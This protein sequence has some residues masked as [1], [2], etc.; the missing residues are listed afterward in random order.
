M[1]ARAGRISNLV[2]VSGSPKNLWDFSAR[3]KLYYLGASLADAAAA[4]G[5]P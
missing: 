2:A 5:L 1:R 3:S 4:A